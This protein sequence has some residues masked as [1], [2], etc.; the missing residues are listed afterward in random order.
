MFLITNASPS[1]KALNFCSG[2][3]TKIFEL[4]ELIKK[5]VG[6]DGEINWNTIPARPLDINELIGDYSKSKEVLGWNP[7]YSLEEGLK[8]TIDYWKNK[9]R[10]S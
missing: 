8:L 10:E 4:V 1:Y 5:L 6:Y 7:K 2:V 9:L 3:G